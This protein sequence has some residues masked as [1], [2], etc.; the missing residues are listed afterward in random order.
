MNELRAPFAETRVGPNR[1]ALL[2]DGLQAYPAML[3][4]I[5]SAKQTICLETY[6]LRDDEL[7]SR[8]LDALEERARAGV[9]V[10][11]MFDA[12]G[13]D[14]S[15]VNLARLRAAGVKLLLFRPWRYLGS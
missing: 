11:L 1:V 2:K 13:S 8:F 7:G 4:A 9:E 12:F 10:L 15:E 14:V 6:I 5:A 3:E